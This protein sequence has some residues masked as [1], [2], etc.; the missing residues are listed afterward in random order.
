MFGVATREAVVLGVGGVVGTVGLILA[1]GS[2]D[3]AL[4]MVA[5][6]LVGVVAFTHQRISELRNLLTS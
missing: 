6:A 3:I 1:F 5:A 4:G 2:S